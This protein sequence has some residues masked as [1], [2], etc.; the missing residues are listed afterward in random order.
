MVLVAGISWKHL[1]ALFITAVIVVAGLWHWGLHPYQKARI[2]TFVHPMADIQGTGYNAYQSMVAVGSGQAFGKGIGYGTQSKL[3][4]L[5]EYQTDFIFAA[6]AEEWGFVGVLLLLGLFS[7]VVVRTLTI[8]AHAR[9]N[10]E[11]L[12]GMGLAIYFTAQFLVHAGM[13]LGLMPITGTTLPFMSYGGSH[14]MTE[15][16]ALGILMAMRREARPGAYERKET[17][18]IGAV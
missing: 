4:F 2:M 1:A 14:L 12:F 8:A 6:Y 16:L 5:P 17:E 18:L 3:Q 9:D 13:N 7:I 10:F 11:M 15:Y